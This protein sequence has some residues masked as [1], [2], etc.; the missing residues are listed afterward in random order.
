MIKSFDIKRGANGRVFT[1]WLVALLGGVK[2]C[3]V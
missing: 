2:I 3:G 1:G